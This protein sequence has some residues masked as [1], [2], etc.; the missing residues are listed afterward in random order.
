ML[1]EI[2]FLRRHAEELHLFTVTYNET[3]LR[4]LPLRVRVLVATILANFPNS[5]RRLTR[6]PV[7]AIRHRADPQ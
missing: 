1:N 4:A 5:R 2:Y 6:V 7:V 3:A